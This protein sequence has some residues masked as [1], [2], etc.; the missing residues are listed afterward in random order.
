MSEF[1]VASTPFELGKDDADKW[2]VIHEV[3]REF[4]GPEEG[5]WYYDTGEVEASI[6]LHDFDD[7]DIA[8]LHHLMKKA[9]PNTGSSSSVVPREAE[10]RI[11]YSETRGEDYPQVRPH[12]E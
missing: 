9:F 8:M 12:Y 3:H 6:P 2:M 4:G 7:E 1:E 11:T 5:G 10:Y